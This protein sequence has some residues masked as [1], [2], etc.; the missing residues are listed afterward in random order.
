MTLDSHIHLWL[1]SMASFVQSL[2]ILILSDT[3]VNCQAW[4][5]ATPWF[6]AAQEGRTKLWSFC[7]PTGHILTFP[8]IKTTE[9]YLFM[10]HTNVLYKNLRLMKTTYVRSVKLGPS[11][12]CLLSSIG[13]CGKCR[14][15]TSQI[16]RGTWSLQSV[17]LCAELSKRTMIL[18]NCEYFFEI[19]SQLMNFI[20]HI[21]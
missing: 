1:C 19:W 18:W 21:A 11:E 12:P 13:G 5:K 2:S 16:L 15:A 17:L 9:S 6:F 7:C 14:M 4:D 8:L 20:W 10:Q 3:N